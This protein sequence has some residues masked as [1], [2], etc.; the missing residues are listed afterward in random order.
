VVSTNDAVCECMGVSFV[1]DEIVDIDDCRDIEGVED[2][3]DIEGVATSLAPPISSAAIL[4]DEISRSV[5]FTHSSS[6]TASPKRI[7]KVYV[8]DDQ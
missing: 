5:T 6:G 7:K 1:D 2:C 3:R 8:P 4:A